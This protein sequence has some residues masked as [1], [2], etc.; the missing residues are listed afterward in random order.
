MQ[1]NV[2]PISDA[3]SG[4]RAPVAAPLVIVV[5]TGQCNSTVNVFFQPHTPSN[6]RW[7]WVS[8]LFRSLAL[9]VL[10]KLIANFNS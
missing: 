1:I 10:M 7:K 9:G 5:L 6:N 2:H 4:T 8:P 3:D